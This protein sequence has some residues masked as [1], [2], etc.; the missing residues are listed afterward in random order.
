[1]T[2][3]AAI[4]AFLQA[5][6]KG[7]GIYSEAQAENAG[8]AKQQNKQDEAELNAIAKANKAR[9]DA[10]NALN[11]GGVPNDPNQRD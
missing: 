7:L 10:I 3:L 9:A 5:L 6:A 1:M 8:A 4:L 2:W 11:S